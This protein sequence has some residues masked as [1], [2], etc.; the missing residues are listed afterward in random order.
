MIIM[1]GVSY[2]LWK[3]LLANRA[4]VAIRESPQKQV[5]IREI[6]IHRI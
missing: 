1:V 3:W 4:N 5:I 6:A 2:S